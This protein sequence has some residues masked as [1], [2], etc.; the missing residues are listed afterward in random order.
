M[1]MLSCVEKSQYF[2]GYSVLTDQNI[3]RFDLARVKRLQFFR[4]TL[5]QVV[6]K[7]IIG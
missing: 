1:F 2:E 4:C 5:M 3:K 6:Y 7:F